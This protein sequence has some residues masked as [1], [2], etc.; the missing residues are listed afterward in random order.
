MAD[1]IFDNYI[2]KALNLNRQVNLELIREYLGIEKISRTLGKILNLKI[3]S[4]DE[5][6]KAETVEL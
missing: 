1:K 6:I 4:A 2:K 5:D 3:I